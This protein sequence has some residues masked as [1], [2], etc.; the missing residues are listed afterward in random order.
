SRPACR[1]KASRDAEGR[2]EM[3]SKEIQKMFGFK[4]NKFKYCQ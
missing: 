4:Y 2:C 1:S 3:L